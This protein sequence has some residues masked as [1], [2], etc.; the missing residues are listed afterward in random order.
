MVHAPDFP[1]IPDITS[2]L[3]IDILC[4]QLIRTKDRA[5][6]CSTNIF[7]HLYTNPKVTP[8]LIHASP[9]YS[10]PKPRKKDPAT[11]NPPP[12]TP[13]SFSAV[14]SSQLRTSA[15]NVCTMSFPP[16][17]HSPASKTPILDPAA[18][19]VLNLHRSHFTI[20]WQTIRSTL[21]RNSKLKWAELAVTARFP[22]IG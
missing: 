19:H 8:T 21:F 15:R 22:S 2:V 10:S 17:D 11:T 6:P 9:A 20:R 4:K 14:Q 5:Y 7:R 16:Q 18:A 1:M 3:F 13:S 12:S